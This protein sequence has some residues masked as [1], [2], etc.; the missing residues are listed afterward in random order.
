MKIAQILHFFG[1]ER[2]AKNA[3]IFAKRFSLSAA[4][5][6]WVSIFIILKTDYFKLIQR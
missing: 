2:N 5:P 1:S 4:N 3:K 6:T